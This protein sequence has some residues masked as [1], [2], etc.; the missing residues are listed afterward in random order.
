MAAAPAGD[1]ARVLSAQE[2]DVQ[3]LLATDVHLGTKNCNFQ[4]ERYCYLYKR[5][6]NGINLILSSNQF[7]TSDTRLLSLAVASR[8]WPAHLWSTSSVISSISMPPED[9]HHSPQVMTLSAAPADILSQPC[10]RDQGQGRTTVPAP[11]LPPPNPHTGTMAGGTGAAQAW[12]PAAGHGGMV[13][14][15]E[16]TYIVDLQGCNLQTMF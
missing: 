12:S 2:R 4:M 13:R 1:A 8:A 16:W 6:R 9:L 7:S 5:C 11:S 10:A 15:S 3:M 14:Q